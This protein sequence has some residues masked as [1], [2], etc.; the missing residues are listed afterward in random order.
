[1]AKQ[2]QP[3]REAVSSQIAKILQAQRSRLLATYI[4]SSIVIETCRPSVVDRQ[5]GGAAG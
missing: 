1:M 4:C 5:I 3:A 2:L